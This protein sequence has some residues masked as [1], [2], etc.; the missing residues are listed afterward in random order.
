MKRVILF[1]QRCGEKT[2]IEVLTR[3]EI[4]RD[5]DRPMRR[6][7]CPKCGSGQVVIGE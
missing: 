6:P 7:T 1:C 3:D 5:P 4:E 2:H